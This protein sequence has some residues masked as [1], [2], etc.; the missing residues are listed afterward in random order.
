MARRSSPVKEASEDDG[1][2]PHRKPKAY[3]TTPEVRLALISSGILVKMFGN[4]AVPIFQRI[5]EEYALRLRTEDAEARALRIAEA[6][7]VDD[8][9]YLN[10]FQAKK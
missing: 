8:D 9:F 2:S 7:D 10:K 6:E 1:W 5:E 4:R 3:Y